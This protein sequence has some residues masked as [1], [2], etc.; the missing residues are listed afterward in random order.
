MLRP[1]CGVNCSLCK[2]SSTFCLFDFCLSTDGRKIVGEGI[3]RVVK[4]IR[5]R[6][7]VVCTVV[8]AG[9]SSL[10]AMSNISPCLVRKGP[11]VAAN[12]KLDACIGNLDVM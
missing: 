9:T 8:V 4:P 1:S 6:E 11:R 3:K 5:S 7:I 2:C 10:D 12:L